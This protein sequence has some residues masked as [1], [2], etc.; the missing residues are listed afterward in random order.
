M[1]SVY[2]KDGDYIGDEKMA[3][4]LC[5]LGIEPEM[6][7]KKKTICQIGFDKKN[8]KWY[9]WSHRAIAGF[10][11]GDEVTSK[12]PGIKKAYKIKNLK[13]A[14]ETAIKFAESVA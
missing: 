13:Q 8:K 10:G 1:K 7:S 14:K 2:T 5:K 9:G 11:I 4:K 6:I 3:N 12:T